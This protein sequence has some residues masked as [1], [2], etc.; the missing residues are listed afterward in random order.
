MKWWGRDLAARPLAVR[1]AEAST[2]PCTFVSFVEEAEGSSAG[3][4]SAGGSSAGGSSAER[5]CARGITRSVLSASWSPR[6]PYVRSKAGLAWSPSLALRTSLL[7]FLSQPRIHFLSQPRSPVAAAP[8]ASFT[9]HA[10]VPQAHS[11]RCGQVP[12][13]RVHDGHGEQAAQIGRSPG[14]TG[15]VEVNKLEKD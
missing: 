8:L 10:F 9:D 7:Y 12:G 15:G 1:P 5:C 14:G 3:G 11:P 6:L 2:P 13:C 4:S